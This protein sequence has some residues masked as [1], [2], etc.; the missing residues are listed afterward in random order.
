MIAS[1]AAIVLLHNGLKDTSEALENTQSILDYHQEALEHTQSI[2]DYHQKALESHK[3]VIKSHDG[4]LGRLWNYF[5]NTQ[6]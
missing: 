4:A 6:V 1:L 5:F 2:L 3:A